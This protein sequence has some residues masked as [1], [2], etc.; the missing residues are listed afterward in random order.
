[1]F[2]KSV[3]TNRVPEIPGMTFHK[4][5]TYQ[6]N[7]IQ[8]GATRDTEIPEKKNKIYPKPADINVKPSSADDDA[9]KKIMERLEIL[10]RRSAGSGFVMP[11][12]T[13]TTTVKELEEAYEN[14][15]SNIVLREGLP[16]WKGMM[17]I[18]LY[19][20]EFV[21]TRL[22]GNIMKGFANSQLKYFTQYE[23]ILIELGEKYSG[24]SKGRQSPE[25]RMIMILLTNAIIAVICNYV[26]KYNGM[27]S[28]VAENVLGRISE[29]ISGGGE[30]K[31]I[32]ASTSSMIE[33]FMKTMG[34]EKSTQEDEKKNTER[35]AAPV[36]TSRYAS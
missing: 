7:R 18:F 8:G 1:M 23:R 36:Q 32:I 12:C 14:Q 22:F 20:F 2:A 24:G 15:L 27:A 3:V 31:D 4:K 21:V 29:Y 10:S 13:E 11:V 26:N 16:M 25:M 33:T 19:S 34:Q 28:S 35:P 6:A 5:A 9:K 17:L 30:S